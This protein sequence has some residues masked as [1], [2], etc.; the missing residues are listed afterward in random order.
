MAGPT[1]LVAL[2]HL[3]F[4]DRRV[5]RLAGHKCVDE[6]HENV[7]H[8]PTSCDYVDFSLVEVATLE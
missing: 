4:A 6:P 3:T 5:T 7:G 2:R 1:P 8:L